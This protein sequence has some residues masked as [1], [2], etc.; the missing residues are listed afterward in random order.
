MPILDAHT[1]WIMPESPWIR[2]EK[3]RQRTNALWDGK[4]SIIGGLMDMLALDS[5]GAS[6]RQV[7][8]PPTQN[9]P[10][11]LPKVHAEEYSFI[12]VR[13]GASRDEGNEEKVKEKRGD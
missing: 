9:E 5:T 2:S 4:L 8:V 3:S 12:F 6:N 13:T 11:N 7:L 1:S 10:E